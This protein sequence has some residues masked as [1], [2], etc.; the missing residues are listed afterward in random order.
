MKQ[1]AGGGGNNAEEIWETKPFTCHLKRNHSINQFRI[2][3][4]LNRIVHILWVAA[5]LFNGKSIDS[6]KH[7][8]RYKLK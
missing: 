3:T 2:V 4:I 6:V 8:I 5:I 1:S 7:E